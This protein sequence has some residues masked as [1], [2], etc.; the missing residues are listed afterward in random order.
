MPP[1]MSEPANISIQEEGPMPSHALGDFNSIPIG[2]S[3]LT[4]IISYLKC[5]QKQSKRPKQNANSLAQSVLR[6]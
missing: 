1:V 3:K 4:Y 5:Q 2:D 6:M